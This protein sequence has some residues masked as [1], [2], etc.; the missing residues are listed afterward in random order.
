MTFEQFQA[1]RKWVDDL[2]EIGADYGDENAGFVY[3]RNLHI[4][5]PAGGAAPN[6]YRL[7]I[8]H[9]SWESADLEELERHL[10]EFAR[11]ERL[12]G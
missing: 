2:K 7:Q 11:D 6:L 8:F 10:Y 9:D 3:H 12:F 1:T 5:A 4:I